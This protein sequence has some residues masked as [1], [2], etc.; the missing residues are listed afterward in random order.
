MALKKWES[1]PAVP[2]GKVRFRRNR[3]SARP[4][5]RRVIQAPKETAES[6]SKA[7]EKRRRKETLLLKDQ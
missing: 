7:H 4:G 5:E 3:F 1:V 6:K 2:K